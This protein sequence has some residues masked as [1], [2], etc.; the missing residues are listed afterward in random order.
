[1]RARPRSRGSW[2][3]L[4]A[5]LALSACATRN[6]LQLGGS[7][8][9]KL[10]SLES[11]AARL[12]RAPAADWPASVVVSRAS[13]LAGG[14]LETNAERHIWQRTAE[15]SEPPLLDRE[16]VVYGQGSWLQAL[17]ARS[18]AP[19]WTLPREGA[20]LR[21][22]ADDGRLSALALDSERGDRHWLLTVDRAGRERLRVQLASELGT[23]ALLPGTIIVPWAGRFVSAIDLASGTELARAGVEPALR[24]ALWSGSELSL[25]GPPWVH[26]ASSADPSSQVLRPR[27]FQARALPSRP[28][29]GRV[30]LGSGALAPQRDPETSL[31]FALPPAAAADAAQASP[32]L[33]TQGRL[34]LSFE[35]SRGSLL[36]LRLL[37]SPILAAAVSEASFALCDASG[38]VW[39]LAASSAQPIEQLQLGSLRP[40]EPWS[41][42]ALG[43]GRG[44]PPAPRAEAG[45]AAPDA[46]VEQLAR[47]L[48]LSAPDV[49][50]VQRFLSRELAARP[51]PEATR[52]LIA[53][54][55]RQNA[56]PLLQAEAE[57]LL[58]TRRNGAEFMLQALERAGRGSRDPVA[59]APL[60]ALADALAALEERR[61]APLL[62]AQMNQLGHSAPALERVARALEVL[63]SEDEY[64]AL[65]VFFSVRRTTADGPELVEAVR[66]VGRTLLRIGGAPGRRLVQLAARDPLTAPEVRVELERELLRH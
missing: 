27:T 43:A 34:A 56:D 7:G 60:A 17:D 10:E 22:L 6:E 12:P 57:D 66:S 28:L 39:V 31:L 33:V 40:G 63:A 64:G 19:L 11:F 65:R 44:W 3:G 20:R 5:L 25:V 42:C 49:A 21:A 52:V 15:V 62:A 58:A 53:L 2:R 30:E 23:P 8:T 59:R 54:A 36:W 61:A 50:N 24:H 13:G 14:V 35:A 41:H 4:P 48:A 18:G 51:E 1:M 26:L 47:V 37:A 29:P 38:S 16:L 9:R 46:L 32:F 55:S 45:G